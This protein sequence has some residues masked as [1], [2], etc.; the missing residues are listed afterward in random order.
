VSHHQAHG[1]SHSTKST[2]KSH[3]HHSNESKDGEGFTSGPWGELQ[4]EGGGIDTLLKAG[5]V[6]AI[7]HGLWEKM[8][9]RD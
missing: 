1:V 6:E 3:K 7:V 2:T 5:R 4:R 8:V 9:R